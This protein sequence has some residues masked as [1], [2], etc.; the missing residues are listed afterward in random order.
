L[1]ANLLDLHERMATLEANY[2]IDTATLNDIQEKVNA[3]HDEMVR[4]KG[5]VGAL[6]FLGSG[7][8]IAVT[9]LKDWF[10]SHWK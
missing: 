6:T 3:F 7:A 4:Y 5:F 1:D 8:V 2:R 10:L 9:L